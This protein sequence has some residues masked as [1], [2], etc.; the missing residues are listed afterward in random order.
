[1]FPIN[2]RL[3][4]TKSLLENNNDF[5]QVF[6]LKNGAQNTEA[7]NFRI[8]FRT[9][10]DSAVLFDTLTPYT[11]ANKQ[12]RILLMLVNGELEL[13]IWIGNNSKN[14]KI[15]FKNFFFIIYCKFFF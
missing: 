13:K 2:K 4:L 7:E 12:D 1:M 11:P 15:D 9:K 14:V 8:K 10:D 5:L 3:S 6:Q